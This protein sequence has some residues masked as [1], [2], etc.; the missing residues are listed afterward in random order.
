MSAKTSMAMNVT[1][2][3]YVPTLKELIFV[4]VF[5]VTKGTAGSVQV[6]LV[7]LL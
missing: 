3:P 1:L 7:A 4:A 5:V 2:T 6:V